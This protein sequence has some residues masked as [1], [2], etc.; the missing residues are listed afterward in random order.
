[1]TEQDPLAALRARGKAEKIK[2]LKRALRAESVSDAALGQIIELFG[3]DRVWGL[4]AFLM[5][6][7]DQLGDF[8]PLQALKRQD[9]E[10]DAMTLRLAR[11]AA[12]SDGFG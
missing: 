2:L 9:S 8:S 7:D 12:D 4:L 11:A 1:M 5:T 10:L 6:P 3:A